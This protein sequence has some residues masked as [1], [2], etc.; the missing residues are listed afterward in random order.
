[1]CVSICNEHV[2]ICGHICADERACVERKT[3]GDA[4]SG[5][6][7]RDTEGEDRRKT[8]QRERQRKRKIKR[9]TCIYVSVSDIHTDKAS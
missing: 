6:R 7:D 2:H 4:A 9:D 5:F 3:A 8:G 1:M